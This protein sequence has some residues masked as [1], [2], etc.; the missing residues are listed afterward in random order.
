MDGDEGA[1]NRFMA[2]QINGFI[3]GAGQRGEWSK[4]FGP[5]QAILDRDVAGYLRNRNSFGDAVVPPGAGLSIQTDWLYGGPLDQSWMARAMGA[6]SPI[7]IW[8]D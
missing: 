4:L 1:I 7:K 3:P 8:Y 6:Y 2:G 5:Y